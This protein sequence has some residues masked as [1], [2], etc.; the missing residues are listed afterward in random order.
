M[1]PRRNKSNFKIYHQHRLSNPYFSKK[2]GSSA[3][4]KLLLSSRSKLYFCLS[5]VIFSILSWFFFYS[6]FFIISDWEVNGVDGEKKEDINR[7]VREQMEYPKL[8]IFRQKN[9][10]LFDKKKLAENI[11]QKYNPKQILVSKNIFKKNLLLSIEERPSSFVWKEENKYFFSDESGNITS[12][13]EPL[14]INSQDYPI[15]ENQGGSLISGRTINVSS[16]KIKKIKDLFEKFKNNAYNINIEKFILTPDQ[17]FKIKI[18]S[19]PEII[20][21]SQVNIDDQINKLIELREG[22]LKNNFDTLEYIDLQFGDRIY[23]R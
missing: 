22:K 2:R 10:F 3:N 20:L 16:D 18:L 23:Y 13:T 14:S 6:S 15:I 19:G 7:L 9:I 4:K 1:K 5:L 17:S 21:N 12:E 11:N 8:F